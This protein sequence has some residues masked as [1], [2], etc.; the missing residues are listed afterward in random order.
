MSSSF[1]KKVFIFSGLA[2]SAGT[3]FADTTNP[4]FGPPKVI[5]MQHQTQV[6][7][8]GDPKKDP[9]EPW[10]DPKCIPLRTRNV[11]MDAIDNSRSNGTNVYVTC[12]QN[13]VAVSQALG[14]G[15]GRSMWISNYYNTGY[16]F[17][18]TETSTAILCCPIVNTW[19][20]KKP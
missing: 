15:T 7:Y 5:P 12:P 9:Q 8:T 6:T 17:S 14:K 16:V 1:I 10:K 19:T 13:Y 4:P 20:P 18:Q 2:L 3:L 11:H